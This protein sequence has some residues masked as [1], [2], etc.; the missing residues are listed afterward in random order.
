MNSSPNNIPAPCT[1]LLETCQ[2]FKK[3]KKEREKKKKEPSILWTKLL[4]NMPNTLWYNDASF[5][6]TR[7]DS[8]IHS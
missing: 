4:D 3:K 2:L 7:L 8:K 1:T 5:P 6:G